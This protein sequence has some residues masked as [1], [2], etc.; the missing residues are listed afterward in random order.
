MSSKC[1]ISLVPAVMRAMSNVPD[2]AQ[3]VKTAY[4]INVFVS[5]EPLL[6]SFQFGLLDIVTG[7]EPKIRDWAELVQS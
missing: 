6:P 2:C 3:E 4:K 5:I 1:L 7:K